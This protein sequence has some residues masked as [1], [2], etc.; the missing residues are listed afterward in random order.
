MSKACFAALHRRPDA[1]R[2]KNLF[3]SSNADRTQTEQR[4]RFALQHRPDTDK[5]KEPLRSAT[6]TGRRQSKESVSHRDPTK[7]SAA[8]AYYPPTAPAVWVSD[9]CRK[10]A[11]GGL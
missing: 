10:S 5:T 4:I 6:Q 2:T 3:R 11:G 9:L 8:G 1:D 7:R